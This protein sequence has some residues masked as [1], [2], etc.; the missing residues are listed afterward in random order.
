MSPTMYDLDYL[1]KLPKHNVFVSVWLGSYKNTFKTYGL[2]TVWSEI[3]VGHLQRH[4]AWQ[5][6]WQ[7]ARDGSYLDVTIYICVCKYVFIHIYTYL[8][9]Y[10]CTYTRIYTSIYIH[11]YIYTCIHIYIYIYTTT[12]MNIYAYMYI[13][14]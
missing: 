2:R 7:D 3:W 8:Y 5:G 10:M 11:M 4:T 1:E 12:T 6:V 9:M 13:Y 14:R